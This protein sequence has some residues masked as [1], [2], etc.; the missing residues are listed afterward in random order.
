MNYDLFVKCHKFR[1]RN[2][3][4]ESRLYFRLCLISVGVKIWF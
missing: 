2:T 1:I 3:H 4:Y